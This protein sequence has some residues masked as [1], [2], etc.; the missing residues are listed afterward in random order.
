MT[1]C[2]GMIWKWCEPL[3][4]TVSIEQIQHHSVVHFVVLVLRHRTSIQPTSVTRSWWA[5]TNRKKLMKWWKVNDLF[6]PMIAGLF[7]TT[8]LVNQGLFPLQ[9]GHKKAAVLLQCKQFL[10]VQSIHTFCA[11]SRNVW[12]CMC[13]RLVGIQQSQSV[14][15]VHFCVNSSL[16]VFTFSFHVSQSWSSF[17][18]TKWECQS[19]IVL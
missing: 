5:K 3:V 14:L 6:E 11:R 15:F 10:A 19:G 16:S 18:H 8:L 2:P 9:A 4:K 7:V 17:M 1:I 13:S 12:Q